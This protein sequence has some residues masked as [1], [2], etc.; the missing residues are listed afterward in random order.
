MPV[1]D[2]QEARDVH[3]V[4]DRLLAAPNFGSAV[5]RLRQL[6]VEKL[7]F[8]SAAGSVSLRHDALPPDATRVAQRDGAAR[9]DIAVGYLFISGFNALAEQ[10]ARLEKTRVLAGLPR[11]S[12]IRERR[13]DMAL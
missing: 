11:H 5:Q 13:S 1:A 10:L 8:E 7:D 6:F 9:A 4:I 3:D 12:T 2:L